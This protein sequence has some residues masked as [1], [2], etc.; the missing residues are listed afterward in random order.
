MAP[1]R[2]A[3]GLD[4]RAGAA[5]SVA[6][7]GE[8]DSVGVGEPPVREREMLLE[9]PL[10]LMVGML[11]MEVVTEVIMLPDSVVEDA[12]VA[13]EA[14]DE[15]DEASSSEPPESAICPM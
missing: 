13:V 3:M 11:A 2:S 5:L 15:A 1:K 8:L 12:S 7:G 10:E 6:S 4:A 14:A 9:V